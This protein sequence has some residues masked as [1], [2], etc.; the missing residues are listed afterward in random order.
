MEKVKTMI[1]NTTMNNT[2]NMNSQGLNQQKEKNTLLEK[3]QNQMDNLDKRIESIKNNEDMSAQEKQK[4]LELIEE[5]KEELI[6]RIREEELK[7]KMEEAEKKIEEA[8]EQAIKNKEKNHKPPTELEEIQAETGITSIPLKT[9]I[10]ASKALDTAT[11]KLSIARKLRQDAKI[12][13]KQV[14]TDRGRGQSITSNDY[15]V[16]QSGAYRTRAD[17][18]EQEAMSSLGQASQLVKKASKE[19]E[20]SQKENNRIEEHIS[21]ERQQETIEKSKKD[22][23]QEE[24][25]VHDVQL[26]KNIDVKL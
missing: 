16:K 8:E 11:N 13:G 3:L 22:S 24:N 10:K 9:M 18:I 20:S 5:Q 6:I 12:L 26:G 17:R 15:R 7:D 19:V 23:V 1:I 25:Q 21:E 14:E 4:K 2:I